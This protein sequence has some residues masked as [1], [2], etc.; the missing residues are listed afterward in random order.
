MLILLSSYTV[1][2]RC[3]P[4]IPIDAF[5][6]LDF[7]RGRETILEDPNVHCPIRCV[8]TSN[9]ILERDKAG[10]GVVVVANHKTKVYILENFDFST[11]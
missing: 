9:I 8:R 7:E 5:S 1:Q 3:I 6:R 10:V 4:P 11:T 2:D